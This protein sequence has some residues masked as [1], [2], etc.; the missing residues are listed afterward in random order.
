VNSIIACYERW[1]V[2]W[3]KCF[4]SSKLSSS[5]LWKAAT[6]NKVELGEVVTVTVIVVSLDSLLLLY[7]TLYQ[8]L[9]WE[10]L[11]QQH[12]RALKLSYTSIL[13]VAFEVS[14]S[15]RLLSMDKKVSLKRSCTYS[16]T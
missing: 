5:I 7:R 8:H 10:Y 1:F 16:S 14:L 4:Y 9:P 2:N 11:L 15:T 3:P 13:H 6:S 12:E